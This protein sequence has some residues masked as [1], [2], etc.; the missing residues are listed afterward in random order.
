MQASLKKFKNPCEPKWHLPLSTRPDRYS[1]HQRSHDPTGSMAYLPS[2][3]HTLYSLVLFIACAEALK[4][5]LEAAS[6]GDPKG[7]RCIRN[8]VAKDTLV[9]VTATIDGSKGDG[10]IVNMHAS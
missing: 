7:K 10:M 1:S 5:D 3:W 4:F 6:R 8:F 2:L 9:V